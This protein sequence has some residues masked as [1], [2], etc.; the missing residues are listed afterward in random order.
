MG[1]GHCQG[2]PDREGTTGTAP[3]PCLGARAG[4]GRLVGARTA[5]GEGGLEEWDEGMGAR[6]GLG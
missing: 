1:S 2:L 5:E 4:A 6:G 3:H